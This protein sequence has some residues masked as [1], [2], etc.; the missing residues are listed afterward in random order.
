M[1]RK[2]SNIHFEPER[3]YKMVA[4]REVEFP[5]SIGFARQCGRGLSALAQVIG[6]TAIPHLGKYIPLLSKSQ[7]QNLGADLLEFAAPEIGEVVS[8]RKYFKTA[9]KIMGRQTL[10]KQF[11]CGS[12]K[13]TAST[14]I[15]TKSAKQTSRSQRD[16]FTNI[17]HWSFQAIFGTN[18][19]WQILE[20][21]DGKSE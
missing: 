5:F 10:R 20:I 1:F 8:G 15:P 6:G 16:V 14:A 19:F 13:K 12:K 11:G 18:L 3:H 2:A 9:A 4:S 17:S 7:Q 21:L